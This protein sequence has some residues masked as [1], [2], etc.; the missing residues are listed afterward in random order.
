MSVVS[1][2]AQPALAGLIGL[3]GNDPD[4]PSVGHLEEEVAASTTVW[5]CR[6]HVLNRH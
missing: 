1:L 3:A 5:A 6:Q 4:N 2:D